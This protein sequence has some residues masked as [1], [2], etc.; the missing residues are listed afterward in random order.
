MRKIVGILALILCASSYASSD[1]LRW[2]QDN[3]L[4]HPDS[5]EIPVQFPGGDE[6]LLEFLKNSINVP[7]GAMRC[8]TGMI[9]LTYIIE[10]NGNVSNIRIR[11]GFGGGIREEVVRVFGQMPRWSPGAIDGN[12]KRTGMLM[13]IAFQVKDTGVLITPLLSNQAYRTFMRENNLDVRHPDSVDI[14]AQFPGGDRALSAFLRENIRY[15]EEARRNNIQGT[16]YLSFIIER[17]GSVSNVRVD[18]SIS[19]CLDAEAI[20]VV[21][22]MPAWTPAMVEGEPVRMSFRIPVRFRMTNREQERNHQRVHE[23]GQQRNRQ[24]VNRNRHWNN[25]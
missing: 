17:D 15:P 4:A 10:Q 13:T 23:Q 11:R 12:L 20:R 24:E 3:R 19:N 5:L 6:A 14:P 9:T 22:A 25:R 1:Y 7:E 21:R 18:C 16:V 8:A 2:L